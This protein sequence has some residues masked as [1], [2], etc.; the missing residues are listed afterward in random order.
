MILLL[1]H[2][3]SAGKILHGAHDKL[4]LIKRDLDYASSHENDY[5]TT[6]VFEPSSEPA[7]GEI[8]STLA[9]TSTASATLTTSTAVMTTKTT[10][11]PSAVAPN[12]NITISLSFLGVFLFFL[13]VFVITGC[14]ERRA[15]QQHDLEQNAN[16]TRGRLSEKGTA[17]LY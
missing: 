15:S 7:L 4:S 6:D 3:F 8:P 12:L 9:R 17:S 1:K 2:T 11:S 16:S 5:F 13:F 14:R 10:I